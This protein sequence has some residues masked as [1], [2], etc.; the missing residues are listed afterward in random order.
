MERCSNHCDERV[1]FTA[2][3]TVDLGCSPIPALQYYFLSLLRAVDNKVCFTIKHILTKEN[4]MLFF[5]HE[6]RV[7]SFKI[8]VSAPISA[9]DVR[10]K[11][12][13]CKLASISLIP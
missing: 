8:H 6:H 5:L 12:V 4:R 2:E 1:P 11:N 13:F 3:A 9:R 7:S 10:E